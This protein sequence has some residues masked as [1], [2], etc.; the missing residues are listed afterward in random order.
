[1]WLARSDTGGRMERLR[2]MAELGERERVIERAKEAYPHKR[3]EYMDEQLTIN[4]L[5]KEAVQEVAKW[6]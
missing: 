4:A 6:D 5:K 2:R 3:Y 1:M